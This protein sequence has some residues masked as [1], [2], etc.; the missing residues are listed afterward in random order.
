MLLSRT[1]RRMSVVEDVL[2]SNIGQDNGGPEILDILYGPML[3]APHSHPVLD[4]CV[5]VHHPTA[6]R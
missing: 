6:G 5:P 4:Y 1:N 2:H 3:P